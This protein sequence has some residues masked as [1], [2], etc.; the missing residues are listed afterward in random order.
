MNREL[1]LR[2]IVESPPPG[3][4]YALQKGS[5]SSYETE[6]QQRS[7]GKDLAFE[8]APAIKGGVSDPM[9]ALAG[10]FVQGPTGKRFVYLD[11]GACAGQANSC[12]SRRLKVPLAGITIKMIRSGGLIEARVPG[13]G[14][15]GSPTCATV[16]DFDGWKCVDE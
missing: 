16:K 4:D 12:W 6:Q 14:Q 11:I 1:R 10:P 2:I 15:D 13:T 5:G 7:Q 3:V 9:A 8:F